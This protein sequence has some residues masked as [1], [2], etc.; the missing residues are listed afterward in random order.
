MRSAAERAATALTVLF[1]V[2]LPLSISV[3]EIALGA[4]LLLWVA[5]LIARWWELPRGGV[6]RLLLLLALWKLVAVA[7]SVD[8]WES[9]KEYRST[10][11][12]LAVPI[13]LTF[14]SDPRRRIAAVRGMTWTM[15]VVFLYACVQFFTGMDIVRRGADKVVGVYPY[16]TNLYIAHGTFNHHLTFANSAMMALLL[17]VGLTAV[18]S[19]RRTLP[20]RLLVILLGAFALMASASRGPW[21]G[22]AAGLLLLGVLL[23]ARATAVVGATALALAAA[24]LIAFPP[25]AKRVLSVGD[26]TV[27][28]ERIYL[29]ESAVAMIAD[30]PVTGI[31]PGVYSLCTPPYREKYRFAFQ[32]NCHAHNTF[33]QVAIETGI[34]GLILLVAFLTAWYR[35]VWPLARGGLSGERGLAL[36]AV[37]AI[38]GFLVAGLTQ[39]NFGDMENVYMLW[40]VIGIALAARANS[41]EVQGAQTAS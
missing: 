13:L 21:M 27:N 16:G 24:L 31:G 8:Q 10:W 30:N 5:G 40:F 36:G 38:T 14:A 32:T 41:T 22:L 4:L 18:A 28:Q 23:G 37:L 6:L 2:A 26:R 11:S 7:F 12:Y 39:H 29:W 3:T 19:V 17:M 34:P 33:L 35:R 25:V 9:L 20:V 15:A 1:A